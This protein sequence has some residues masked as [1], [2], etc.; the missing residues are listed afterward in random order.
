MAALSLH[1]IALPSTCLG[2]LD[3]HP[4]QAAAPATA[5]VQH[6]H[7]AVAGWPAG[8][9]EDP[10]EPH[11][12]ARS[13]MLTTAI[14]DARLTDTHL[15]TSAA[16]LSRPAC[17]SWPGQA[18]LLA[19]ARGHCPAFGGGPAALSCLD[20]DGTTQSLTFKGLV[21]LSTATPF[22]RLNYRCC[23]RPY[24]SGLRP[25]TWTG[26]VQAALLQGSL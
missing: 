15:H 5:D 20:A 10:W 16:A 12:S 3:P 8:Q 1:G 18:L 25:Q 9:L 19:H 22:R 24:N 13:S 17:A 4:S 26:R 11:M 6:T 7:R 2:S 14:S 21:H 23:A